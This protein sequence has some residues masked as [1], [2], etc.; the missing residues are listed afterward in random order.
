MADVMA[1]ACCLLPSVDKDQ[2]EAGL[3]VARKAVELGKTSPYLPLFQMG[4]G[5]AEYRSGRF[6]EAEARLHAAANGS[7]TNPSTQGTYTN[8]ARDAVAPK[9]AWQTWPLNRWPPIP[10][11]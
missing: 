8:G 1:R 9:A 3:A 6:T 10:P 11:K 2:A 7:A 4:L 5:M